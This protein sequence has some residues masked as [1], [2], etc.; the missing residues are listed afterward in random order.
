MAYFSLIHKLT[1]DVAMLAKSFTITAYHCN[2]ESGLNQ[3]II[4]LVI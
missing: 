1:S 3:D 4:L 2:I